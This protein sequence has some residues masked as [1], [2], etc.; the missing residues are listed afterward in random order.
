ML[1]RW[2]GYCAGRW[3]ARSAAI[4]SQLVPGVRSVC[5]LCSHKEY[6]S[7]A[8]KSDFPESATPVPLLLLQSPGPL[9][10]LKRWDEGERANLVEG[11][12]PA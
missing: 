2:G 12:G 7:I 1:T 10:K 3:A 4:A 8:V 9:Q 5:M 11:L 6:I